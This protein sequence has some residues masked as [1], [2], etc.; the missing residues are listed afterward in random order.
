VFQVSYNAAG[1]LAHMVSD[2]PESW[3]IKEPNREEVLNRISNAIYRWDLDSKRNINYRSFEP[4]LRLL[5][6]DHTP[7]CQYWAVW[8]LANLTRF[9][10]EKYC[11]LLKEENGFPLLEDLIGRTTHLEVKRFAKIALEGS[12]IFL[13]RNDGLSDASDYLEG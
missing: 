8:A 11:R 10:S 9:Y 13:E 1:V 4:I 5:N 3:K 12:V 6:A 7:E 2:G